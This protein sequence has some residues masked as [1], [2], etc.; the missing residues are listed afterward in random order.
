MNTKI[1]TRS[2]LIE[3]LI[4][5]ERLLSDIN[6]ELN[7][8]KFKRLN[9]SGYT[10]RLNHHRKKGI[11]EIEYNQ[12]FAGTNYDNKTFGIK[13]Y[14]VKNV[15]SEWFELKLLVDK[16]FQ[17]SEMMDKRIKQISL[18]KSQ[19]IQANAR[20]DVK[21]IREIETRIIQLEAEY[22]ALVIQKDQLTDNVN[23]IEIKEKFQ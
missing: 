5:E 14:G 8:H 15:I 6:S 11:Y 21:V 18:L 4:K 17:I 1:L 16:M 2:E 7:K 12:K 23:N 19:L 22:Q 3:R 20:K 13:K 10:K 9:K